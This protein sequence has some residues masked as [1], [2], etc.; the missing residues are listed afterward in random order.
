[1]HIGPM[2]TAL[3]LS[4]LGPP[5]SAQ[6]AHPNEV[7]GTWRMVQATIDPDGENI[8]AYGPNPNSL[9]IFTPDMHYAAVLTNGDTPRFASDARGEG[10]DAENRIAIADS[11]GFFGTYTVDENG[12]FSGNRV[13]G[14]TFPNWVGSARTTEELTMTVRGNRMF[15]TFTRPEG[16]RIEIIWERVD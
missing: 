8:P 1:M 12:V 13:D 2:A 16:A 3:A 14:A 10:T 11:I 7:V 4:L 5:A 9:L 15:E 6:D